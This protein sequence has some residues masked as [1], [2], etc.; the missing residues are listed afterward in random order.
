MFEKWENNEEYL[1]IYCH[2]EHDYGPC[3]HLVVVAERL[4]TDEEFEKRISKEMN[5]KQKEIQKLKNKEEKLNEELEKVK[6][7]IEN[8]QR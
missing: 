6:T 2:T 4:E 7:K 3:N 5:K 8:L 1:N